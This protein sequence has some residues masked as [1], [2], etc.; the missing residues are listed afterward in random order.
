MLGKEDETNNKQV[1][2]FASDH[3]GFKLK[4]S[5]IS[6][7]KENTDYSIIDSGCYSLESCHY[8]L[9]A[10]EGVKNMKK[11]KDSKGVFICS[12]GI[13]ISIAANRDESISACLCHNLIEVKKG[14]ELNC[15]VIVFGELIVEN[16]LAIE[17]LKEFFEIK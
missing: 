14:K 5:L 4:Q 7:M 3:A 16:D 12:T 15:N 10:K 8:P 9:Y 13:G 1:V 11:Y 6:Y 2:V 17:M